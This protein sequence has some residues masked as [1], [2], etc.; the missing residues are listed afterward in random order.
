MRSSFVPIEM[1]PE[2]V[3]SNY[4]HNGVGVALTTAAAV[5]ASAVLARALGPEQWDVYSQ[6]TWLIGIAVTVFGGGLTYTAMRYLGTCSMSDDSAGKARIAAWRP[7][8]RYSRLV[9]LTTLADQVIW[10]RPE[11]FFFGQLADPAQSGY[12]SPAYT[13]AGIAVGTVR[14]ALT[15]TLTAQFSPAVG[16]LGRCYSGR[17]TTRMVECP[18]S[19]EGAFSTILSVSYEHGTNER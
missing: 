13:I 3:L 7:M 11:V 17:R 9:L 16:G 2:T 18:H 6:V 8:I 12:Y 5:V 19:G 14:T 10:Q 15:G 1:A 4:L